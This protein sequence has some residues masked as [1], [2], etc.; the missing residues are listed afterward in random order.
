MT[1]EPV[2]RALELKIR[3]RIYNFILKYPGLHFRELMRKLNLPNGTLG[4]HLKYLEKRG[5]ITARPGEGYVRYYIINNI[6]TDQKKMFHILRQ[7]TPRNII[8]FS[9]KPFKS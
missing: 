4:Y 2:K 8:L 7:E 5:L 9:L 1:I 3:R 6:G